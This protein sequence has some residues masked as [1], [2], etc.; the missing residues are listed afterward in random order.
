MRWS[1]GCPGV[2]NA[3]PTTRTHDGFVG[4]GA[5]SCLVV[6]NRGGSRSGH[7][8]PS[9]EGS[10]V[11]FARRATGPCVASAAAAPLCERR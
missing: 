10:H 2:R 3:V 6:A 5:G 7:A 11:P 1:V 4:T 9:T 8:C